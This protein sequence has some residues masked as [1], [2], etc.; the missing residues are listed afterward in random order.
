MFLWSLRLVTFG[1]VTAVQAERWIFVQFRSHNCGRGSPIA[2]ASSKDNVGC[3]LSA[4]GRH[5]GERELQLHLFL[6]SEWDGGGRLISCHGQCT[7][8]GKKRGNIWIVGWMSSIV[9]LD[10]FWRKVSCPRRSRTPDR[11]AHSLGAIPA[12]KCCCVVVCY[13]ERPLNYDREMATVNGGERHL[14][15][16]RCCGLSFVEE[17]YTIS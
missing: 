12:G 13:H 4:A 11:P 16:S 9:D 17:S 10:F 14:C 1:W 5:T 6:S 15:L 8:R 2:V 7:P 3:S